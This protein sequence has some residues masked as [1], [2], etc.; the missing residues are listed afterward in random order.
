MKSEKV[1]GFNRIYSVVGFWEKL[2]KLYGKS[3]VD[4]KHDLIK[5]RAQLLVLDSALDIYKYPSFERLSGTDLSAIR[6]IDKHN[7]R[8]IFKVEKDN[9]CLLI[10]FFEKNKSDY[11]KALATALER[12][13]ESED[14]TSDQESN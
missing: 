1:D 4:Y 11:Q 13:K 12:A 7:L 5:L 2:K 10:A 3:T 8:I 6:M 14:E 9:K